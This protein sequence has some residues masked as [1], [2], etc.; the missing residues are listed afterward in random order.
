LRPV[1]IVGPHLNNAPTR[2]LKLKTVPTLL[3][4][5]PII[6]VV[7]ETDTVRAFE[8]ALKPSVR[9]IFNIV[10]AEQAPLSRI[11]EARGA[12]ALPLPEILFRKF[13]RAA[14]R[15]G[16]TTYRPGEIDHLK[17]T[18]LVDGSH[19]TKELS[20]KPNKTLMQSLHDL[21]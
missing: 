7:H 21:G 16:L 18:C 13:I 10:G 9:G 15:R 14:F 2:Y 8:L 19:A 11:I 4:Y 20:F 12:R 1:H 6:Q 3:G 17:Y 5:D